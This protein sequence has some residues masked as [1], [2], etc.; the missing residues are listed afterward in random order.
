MMW[1]YLCIQRKLGFACSRLGSSFLWRNPA[2]TWMWLICSMFIWFHSWPDVTDVHSWM[3]IIIIMA[4]S[5]PLTPIYFKIDD[6]YRIAKQSYLHWLAT[7]W[8]DKIENKKQ[9]FGGVKR[10]YVTAETASTHNSLR[11]P[12]CCYTKQQAPITR[13]TTTWNLIES[14]AYV[15][16]FRNVEYQICKIVDSVTQAQ[17]SLGQIDS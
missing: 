10:F 3:T 8:P 12:V 16:R 4:V 6:T 17:Q 13:W 2:E 7:T 1:K 15:V 14:L 5:K 11:F 9:P